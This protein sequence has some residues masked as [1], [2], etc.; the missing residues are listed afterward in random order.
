MW[1]ACIV[2]PF[3]FYIDSTKWNTVQPNIF[4]GHFII[5]IEAAKRPIF[6]VEQLQRSTA[7]AGESADWTHTDTTNPSLMDKS[8]ENNHCWKKTE[9]YHLQ[10]GKKCTGHFRLKWN[11]FNWIKD[12]MSGRKWMLN[13]T[14]NTFSPLWSTV[15]VALC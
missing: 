10:F 11:M 13:I 3:F 6:T 12:T 15:V 8:K 9:K 7:Q 4:R 2:S 5:L 14:L 1:H